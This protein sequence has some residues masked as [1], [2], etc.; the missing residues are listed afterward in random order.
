MQEKDAEF[1]L[2]G[3]MKKGQNLLERH[4]LKFEAAEGHLKREWRQR[5]LIKMKRKSRNE[6]WRSVLTELQ[7]EMYRKRHTGTFLFK[8]ADNTVIQSDFLH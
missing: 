2:K 7:D 6:Q 5:G 8:L 1:R 3:E 4:T